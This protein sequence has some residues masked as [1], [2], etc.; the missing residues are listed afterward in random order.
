MT[1][2]NFL[3]EVSNKNSHVL[4]KNQDMA[5]LLE[6]KSIYSCYL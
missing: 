6:L 4:S 5:V 2:V 3:K 1:K